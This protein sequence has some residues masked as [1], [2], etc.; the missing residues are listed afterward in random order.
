[1][2]V[3]LT[4]ILQNISKVFISLH[5]Q[6]PSYDINFKGRT[7]ET[8]SLGKHEP[9]LNVCTCPMWK[10]FQ[11]IMVRLTSRV[12]RIITLCSLSSSFVFIPLFSFPWK[13]IGS[14]FFFISYFYNWSN[15]FI[16]FNQNRWSHKTDTINH[17]IKWG[18][19]NN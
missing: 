3:M 10:W 14:E 7:W 19:I 18:T 13:K 15:T 11:E 8:H 5:D 2:Q 12:V 1:M 6:W 16:W 17:D 9:F 4:I